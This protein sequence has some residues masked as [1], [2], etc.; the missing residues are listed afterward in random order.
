MG[1]QFLNRKNIILPS[2]L[3]VILTGACSGCQPGTSTPGPSVFAAIAQFTPDEAIDVVFIPDDDY[4][5]LSVNANLQDFLDDIDGMIND[6][7]WENNA[8]YVNNTLFNFW[9][10][11]EQGDVQEVVP[12][13]CPDVDWPNLS[14][15]AFAELVVLLHP[16]TVR[17]CAWGKKVTSEPFSYRTVVHESGHGAFNLPDEYCCDGGYSITSPVLYASQADCEAD[18]TNA[19]W[20]DCQSFTDVDGDTWW[21]SEDMI[22]DI[23]STGGA[24]V[25]EFGQADWVVVKQVMQALGAAS[26]VSDPAVFAPT[27]WTNPNP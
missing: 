12:N 8:M 11:V 20:R 21:R 2:M 4:G 10:M 15:T 24:T 3:L 22:D 18:A 27:D 5:D 13:Q 26:G 14:D 19:A 17:D 1:E 25:L 23:M 7:F 16:N 9:Y 6:G